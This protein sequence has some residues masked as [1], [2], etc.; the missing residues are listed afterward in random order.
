M[1]TDFQDM[2]Y[3]IA[4]EIGRDDLLPEIRESILT[5]VDAHTDEHHFFNEKRTIV[6]TAADQEYYPL[7]AGFL[8]E[9]VVKREDNGNFVQMDRA[10]FPEIDLRQTT[11]E[12]TA[13]PFAFTIWEEQFRFYPR[14][15]KLYR[16]HVA[17]ITSG[18]SLDK[19][20]DKSIWLD[21]AEVV[22]RSRAKRELFEHTLYDVQRAQIMAAT[23]ARALS[24]LRA[25]SGFRSGTGFIKKSTF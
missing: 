18:N 22:I 24:V 9:I 20:A 21:K 7:P 4:R 10:S 3:R 6:E 19:S 15:D 12:Q 5:A 25:K 23:E 14:P 8:M 2:Q 13:E 11:T 17:Y 16:I 1:A